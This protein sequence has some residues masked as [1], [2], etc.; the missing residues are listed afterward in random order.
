MA[1]IQ[2]V[3]IDLLKIRLK[4]PAIALASFVDLAILASSTAVVSYSRVHVA[5]A[6][7]AQTTVA[8]VEIAWL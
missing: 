4:A 2:R 6:G 7:A 3:W 8:I 5:M 1:K